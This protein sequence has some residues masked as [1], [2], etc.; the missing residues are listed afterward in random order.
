M[1]N[2][3]HA[4]WRF[5]FLLLVGAVAGVAVAAGLIYHPKLSSPS[6]WKYRAHKTWTA[7]AQLLVDSN[8]GPF[9]RTTDHII[10]T[11]KT[12]TSK[13]GNGTQTTTTPTKTATTPPTVVPDTSSL[14]KAA[15]LYPLLIMSDPVRRLRLKMFGPVGGT[16]HAQAA[17]SFQ[18]ANRYRPSPLPLIT[19]TATS[20]RHKNP[21]KLVKDTAAAFQS[22][23]KDQQTAQGIPADQRIVL[24][25]LTI[26]RHASAIGGPKFGLPVIAAFGVF[27]AFFGLAVILDRMRPRPGH[28]W[29]SSHATNGAAPPGG[30]GDDLR[31]VVAEMRE[32]L[33]R[34]APPPAAGD[35]AHLDVVREATDAEA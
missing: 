24:R 33:A 35:H 19:I 6:H 28:E 11:S 7:S 16:M 18:G 32:A 27:L 9:L 10:A 4:A 3:L 2:Y 8:G 20:R 25:Q 5:K 15:N 1:S 14:V 30:D 12:P 21:V 22:W 17:L 29:V 13:G 31:D 26:P 23:L 34:L